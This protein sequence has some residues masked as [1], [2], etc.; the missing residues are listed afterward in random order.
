M[1]KL[2]VYI[3]FHCY[4]IWQSFQTIQ[5]RKIIYLYEFFLFRTVFDYKGVNRNTDNCNLFISQKQ[6]I[7]WSGKFLFSLYLNDLF[8]CLNCNIC[9]K[10]D[11]NK[12][13]LSNIILNF[14][15]RNLEE[16]PDIAMFCKQMHK[17]KFRQMWSSF[18][19][20]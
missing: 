6:N 5:G 15:S 3:S 16:Q 18:L 19:A 8:I 20:Q 9:K 2:L 1:L 4:I 12:P 17:R 13:Y 14:T 10:S 7:Y 11:D